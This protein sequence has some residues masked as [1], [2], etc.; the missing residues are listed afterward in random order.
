MFLYMFIYIFICFYIYF[1]M[2]LYTFLYVFIYIC[3]FLYIYMYISLIQCEITVF[4]HL[5]AFSKTCPLCYTIWKNT[6]LVPNTTNTMTD[7]FVPRFQI[8]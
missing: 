4:K 5:F 7:R 2:F 1:Y 6:K 8:G 3:I